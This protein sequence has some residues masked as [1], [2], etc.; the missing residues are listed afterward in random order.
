VQLDAL[1]PIKFGA[2]VIAGWA[3]GFAVAIFK[4]TASTREPKI[5]FAIVVEVFVTDIFCPT[6]GIISHYHHDYGREMVFI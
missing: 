5:V 6:W 3:T 2:D 1:F 4:T